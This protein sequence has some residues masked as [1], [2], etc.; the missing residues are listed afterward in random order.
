MPW[1][2]KRVR[3]KELLDGIE[4]LLT[5]N[6]WVKIDAFFRYVMGPS[7]LEPKVIT[8]TMTGAADSVPVDETIL[9]TR[10]Y[11]VF[12]DGNKA[13]GTDYT[14][15]TVTKELKFPAMGS[16]NNPVFVHVFMAGTKLTDVASVHVAEHRIFRN[17]SGKL[18]GLAVYGHIQDYFYNTRTSRPYF[19]PV[20][21]YKTRQMQAFDAV[22]DMEVRGD[23]FFTWANTQFRTKYFRRPALYAYQLE[24]HIPASFRPSG[25]RICW[26]GDDLKRAVL[27]IEMVRAGY[28]PSYQGIEKLQF[29]VLDHFPAVYQSPIL[30]MDYRN[31]NVETYASLPADGYRRHETNW[32]NDAT[33]TLS[34]FIDVRTALFL[35]QADSSPAFDKNIVPLTPL[36]MGDIDPMEGDTSGTEVV[37]HTEKLTGSLTLQPGGDIQ[38]KTFD[39]TGVLAADSTI[40]IWMTGDFHSNNM[41][42]RQCTVY[43]NGERVVTARGN[44][45]DY[46]VGEFFSGG[47]SDQSDVVVTAETT[48]FID[49]VVTVR[50]EITAIKKEVP[51]YDALFGGTAY[52]GSV[53][54]GSKYSYQQKTPYFQPIFP[55]LKSYPFHP[56]NGID[57]IIVR[58]NKSLARYQKHYISALTWP[59]DMP[60]QRR[61]K[62]GEEYPRAWKRFGNDAY[63]YRFNPSQY[64]NEVESGS[65][66]VMNPEEGKHGQLR[67]MLAI[68]PLSMMNK[69]ELYLSEQRCPDK[70]VEFYYFLT[71]AISPLT[72]RPSVVFSPSAVAVRRSEGKYEPGNF[73]PPTVP[74]YKPPVIT[75]PPIVIPE[76]PPVLQCGQTAESG[77]G[78]K[79][80][81]LH[82]IGTKAGLVVID[83]NMYGYPDQMEVYYGEKLVATTNGPVAGNGSLQFQYTPNGLDVKIK[84]VVT[85]DSDGTG[86]EYTVR[87]PV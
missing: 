5:D 82:E 61:T 4:K 33:I 17:H 58:N 29:Q 39:V 87:C 63:M 40:K 43:V 26:N 77:G 38:S 35:M 28:A 67:H 18:Y 55:L 75:E 8:K 45:T 70:I 66:D 48:Q 86:W 41:Q 71:D 27:D 65:M 22:V 20:R 16:A 2:E 78:Q 7:M 69:D 15:D 74:E 52:K 24:S 3:E 42:H 1:F 30:E 85:S 49:S 72:K 57:T 44:G 54:E 32:F 36:Y 14:V 64:T 84:V 21:L 11:T 56:A 76:K 83:Y 50:F 73:P 81:N 80:E 59:N 37:T 13:G 31:V 46:F 53:E 6:G 10:S 25:H 51:G 62:E 9:L 19:C 23:D 68:H 34:G 79:T 47:F 12:I 60:P